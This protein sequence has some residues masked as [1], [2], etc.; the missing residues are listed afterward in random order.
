MSPSLER[1]IFRSDRMPTLPFVYNKIKEAVENPESSFDDIARVVAND[2][3]LSASL[4]RLANSAFYGYPSAVYS[5]PDALT[6][7]GLQQFKNMA[8]SACIMDVFKGIPPKLANMESFWSKSLACGLCA[9]IMALNLR[10]PNSERFF[11]GGLMCK[12]GRLII[13]KEEPEKALQIIELS[14]QRDEPM[15][16]VEQEIL[17]FDHAEIGGAL[18]DH[19]N[20]PPSISELVRYYHKPVL[21]KVSVQDVSLVH[22]ANFIT[23]ALGMGN[24]GDDFVPEFSDAAWGHSGL[25]ESRL[26]YIVEELQRQYAE[27]RSVFIKC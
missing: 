9:R 4:L 12:I 23:E 8:L 10:E 17:G 24:A 25:D 26:Y 11:L 7:I 2:Q 19:W 18:L 14:R 27:V 20:L 21:A 16:V 6:V 22:L 1:L 13:F 15:H 5:I 3:G